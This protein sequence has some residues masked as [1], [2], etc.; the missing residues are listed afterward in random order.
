LT[1][2]SSDELVVNLALSELNECT[3][4][5]LHPLIYFRL[6]R[7]LADDCR[8]PCLELKNFYRCGSAY[9]VQYEVEPDLSY[10]INDRLI[11]STKTEYNEFVE[12]LKKFPFKCDKELIGAMN[13]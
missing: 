8:L 3:S 9:G 11:E 13:K 1:K 4:F 12:A 10:Q 6:T 5:D 2:I 7:P